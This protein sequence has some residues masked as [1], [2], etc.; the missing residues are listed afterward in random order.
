MMG[1]VSRR[2]ATGLPVGLLPPTAAAVDGSGKRNPDIGVGAGRSGCDAHLRKPSTRVAD[3]TAPALSQ[4]D[5][6]A[7]GE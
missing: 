5:P 7:V 4:S 3:G 1:R 2:G 6:A